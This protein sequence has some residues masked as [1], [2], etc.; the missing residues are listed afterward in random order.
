M[1]RHALKRSDD[2]WSIK[3]QKA[4]ETMRGGIQHAKA[5]MFAKTRSPPIKHNA[6]RNLFRRAFATQTA[7]T[8]FFPSSKSPDKRWQ[9]ENRLDDWQGHNVVRKVFFLRF[10]DI[11]HCR[12]QGFFEGT[13]P[14]RNVCTHLS[15]Y[16]ASW[17]AGSHV[18]PNNHQITRPH[19]VTTQRA[20]NSLTQ[21]A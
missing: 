10:R 19:D 20:K 17:S 2:L 15:P 6:R 9:A 7:S 4:S 11:C 16:T 21:H 18:P 14:F 12:L 3:Q 13:R 8:P 1:D 5:V